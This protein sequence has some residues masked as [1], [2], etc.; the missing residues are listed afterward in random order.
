VTQSQ[1]IRVPPA[2][3]PLESIHLLAV[4]LH[5]QLR[6]VEA[7]AGL[8]SA[9][10]RGELEAAAA[11]LRELHWRLKAILDGAPPGGSGEL[12]RALLELAGLGQP[13]PLPSGGRG[14]RREALAEELERGGRELAATA[15]RCLELFP[16]DE[17]EDEFR[18]LAGWTAERSQA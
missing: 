13:R 16:G 3:S 4:L 17:H 12:E 8:L 9:P 6:R 2:C 14:A 15:A 18:L 5:D 1:T 10:R 7:L 11:E